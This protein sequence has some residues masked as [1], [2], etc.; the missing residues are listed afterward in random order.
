MN[1]K[2]EMNLKSKEVRN[3]LKESILKLLILIVN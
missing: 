1:E 2:N 3:S